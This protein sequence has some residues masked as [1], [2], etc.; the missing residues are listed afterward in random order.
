VSDG[1]GAVIRHTGMKH[2]GPAT[3]P[4][5]REI[6]MRFVRLLDHLLR[7]LAR[8]TRVGRVPSGDVSPPRPH[9]VL[10]ARQA[11]SGGVR[12]VVLALAAA[13][14]AACSDGSGPTDGVTKP[15][16]EL[17]VVHVAPS[18]TPLFNPADSFYAVKGE[19]REVRIYFQDEAGAQGEEY[20]R[21]RIRPSTLLARPDGTPMAAGDSVLIHVSVVDPAQMLFQ[22]EPTGLQFSPAEPAEL[23]I[24]YDHA[25]GDIND[26]GVSNSEDDTLERTLAIWR[27]EN[28]ADPFVRLPSLLTLETDEANADITG[29]SRYALAY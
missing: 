18:S 9:R 29:F 2:Q 20:L 25:D 22:F 26:D 5:P 17:N 19:D 21:L 24:H 10:R 14:V 16:T 1:E 8:G 4:S 27:Q 11:P 6:V 7:R 3:G 13:G 15:P 12:A 28:P 23:K